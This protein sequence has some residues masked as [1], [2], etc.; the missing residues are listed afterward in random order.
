MQALMPVFV[1]PSRPFWLVAFDLR[2]QAIER[3]RAIARRAPA[4]Q[5]LGVPASRGGSPN[6]QGV[7]DIPVCTSAGSGRRVD[8]ETGCCKAHS[9]P[10]QAHSTQRRDMGRDAVA[11]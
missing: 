8:P 11:I 9:S 1:L 5:K 3:D 4:F 7:W 2:F 6:R 10:T